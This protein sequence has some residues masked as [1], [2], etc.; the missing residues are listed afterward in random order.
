MEWIGTERCL[1]RERERIR[2]CFN[3][4]PIVTASPLSS[5]GRIIRGTVDLHFG[6]VAFLRGISN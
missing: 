2:A 5:A 3:C 4:H 6:I 1:K